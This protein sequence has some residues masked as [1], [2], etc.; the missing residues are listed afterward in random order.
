MSNTGEFSSCYKLT[1][2]ESVSKDLRG[3]EVVVKAN[4]RPTSAEDPHFSR[5]NVNELLLTAVPGDWAVVPGF[6]GDLKFIVPPT[7][8][9]G[10]FVYCCRAGTGQ[11]TGN[12]WIAVG[13]GETA[14]GA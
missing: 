2:T 9:T 11:S 4:T 8:T 13:V 14:G 12:T 1:C 6:P 3:E 10:G 7:G 5:L